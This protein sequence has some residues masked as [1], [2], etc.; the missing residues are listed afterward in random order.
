VFVGTWTYRIPVFREQ[1]SVL[2]YTLGGW[3]VS[4]IV[5]Y[6]SGSPVTITGTQVI[7]RR[8]DY[9]GGDIYLAGAPVV[10]AGGVVSYINPAAFAI[11][12]ADRLGN[13]GRGMVLGPA[14][15]NW[16]IS[17]RKQIPLKGSVKA[18]FQA[19]FF[20]AFNNL[21]LRNPATTVTNAG[22]G[23]ITSAAPMRNI[24]LGFRFMF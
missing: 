17:L 16:D 12:P 9:L 24:Q 8:A 3:E 10:G 22:F 2:G 11:A 21:I 7:G 19:D 6:Q 5:R 1:K 15:Y 18:Q 14:Y 4:G 13:S 23:T 20:N